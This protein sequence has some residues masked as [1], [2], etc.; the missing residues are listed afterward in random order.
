[1]SSCLFVCLFVV[2]VVV[3]WFLILLHDF[4]PRFVFMRRIVVNAMS[5]RS[6]RRR[7][8]VPITRRGLTVLLRDGSG[9]ILV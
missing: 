1:M 9:S 8:M 6:R 7:M 4:A 5:R 2:V 3:V